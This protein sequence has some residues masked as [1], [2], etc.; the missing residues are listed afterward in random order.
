MGELAHLRTLKL[1]NNRF[2]ALPA[3]AYT[4]RHLTELDLRDNRITTLPAVRAVHLKYLQKLDLRWNAVK[5]SDDG[6][7][8]LVGRGCIVYL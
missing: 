3:A 8:A 2:T 7:Q 4:M 1:R 6:V 5:P